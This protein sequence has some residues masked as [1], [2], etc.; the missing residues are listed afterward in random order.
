M[1]AGTAAG[2]RLAAPGI[3]HLFSWFRG[4]ASMQAGQL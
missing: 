2:F 4:T 3:R 1:V